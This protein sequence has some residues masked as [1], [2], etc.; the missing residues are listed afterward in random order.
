METPAADRVSNRSVKALEKRASLLKL[1]REKKK[2]S[3]TQLSRLTQLS[4]YQVEGLEGKGAQSLLD[5]FFS[6]TH[7]LG[8]GAGDVLNLMQ[9]S[10]RKALPDILKGTLGK[11]LS[12]TSFQDGA[13]ISTYLH[14]KDNF[15]GLLQLGVGKAIT[16]QQIHRGDTVFGIVREGTLVIDHLVSQT[17]HKKDQCFVLSAGLPARFL[18]GDSFIQVSTLLFSLT[19]PT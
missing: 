18:N 1:L 5:K 16:M 17:V 2:I 8:Y 10:H 3:R 14:S 4:P 15:F 13:K 6:C 12:E 19:Y 7:A 9:S 11:P